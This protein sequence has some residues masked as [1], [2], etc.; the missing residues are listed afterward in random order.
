MK[1]IL[2]SFSNCL[3]SGNILRNLKRE[4][5]LNPKGEGKDI[6]WEKFLVIKKGNWGMFWDT[7]DKIEY[8]FLFL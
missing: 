7:L 1:F 3:T 5:L 6:W 8:I 4:L 2:F